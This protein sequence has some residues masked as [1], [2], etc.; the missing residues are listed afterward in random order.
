MLICWLGLCGNPLDYK[1][2]L[3]YN[4]NHIL[5]GASNVFIASIKRYIYNLFII[6]AHCY[7]LI[8]DVNTVMNSFGLSFSSWPVSIKTSCLST[9]N[10]LHISQWVLTVSVRLRDYC[11]SFCLVI[12]H[13]WLFN[14]VNFKWIIQ[15]LINN[16]P[17]ALLLKPET[18]WWLHQWVYVLPGFHS[19][20]T[21]LQHYQW[22]VLVMLLF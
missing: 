1:S 7:P 20:F 9:V 14:F 4:G 11:I 12:V 16:F 6:K 8:C 10:G 2:S 18:D 15:N 19:F 17:Q 22:Y 21:I 3:C 13:F 5:R